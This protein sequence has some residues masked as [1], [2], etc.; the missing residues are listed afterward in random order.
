MSCCSF[1]LRSCSNSLFLLS[2]IHIYLCI[3]PKKVESIEHE[4]EILIPEEG[5]FATNTFYQLDSP[6]TVREPVSYTHLQ[7][8]HGAGRKLRAAGVPL[9]FKFCDLEG[10]FAFRQNHTVRAVILNFIVP[11]KFTVIRRSK[12]STFMTAPVAVTYAPPALR[13]SGLK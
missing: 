8:G 5:H 4:R 3:D 6:Y 13:S 10:L 1:F 9:P 2:L 12:S 11:A 7:Q